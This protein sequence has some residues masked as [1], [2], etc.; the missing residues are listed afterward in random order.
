MG[1]DPRRLNE[2]QTTVCMTAAYLKTNAVCSD[3]AADIGFLIDESGSVGATNFKINLDLITK[4]VDDFDS[5]NSS[6]KISTFAFHQLI[7]DGFYFSCCNDKASIKSISTV[8][9][10]KGGGQDF[11]MALAFARKV[12][13]KQIME[14]VTSPLKSCCFTDGQ[15]QIQDGEVY[16]IILELLYMQLVLEMM[17]TGTN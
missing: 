13:F 1:A 6:V 3:Q 9:H 10:F 7:G 4:I 12:C 14:A 2:L 16:Y 5:G 8:Y 11:E 15:S 17:W